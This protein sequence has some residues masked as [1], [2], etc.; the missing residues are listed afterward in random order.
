MEPRRLTFT[1]L[2]EIEP[3]LH[4]LFI[5]AQHISDGLQVFRTL[6][7]WYGYGDFRGRGLKKKM[8][9]LVGW[10]RDKGPD[11]MRTCDAYMTAYTTIL[12]AIPDD[13][14]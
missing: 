1:E 8:L 4:S 2:C 9:P 5:E 12:D 10:H 14:G 3:R 13:R 11:I 6:E 7:A